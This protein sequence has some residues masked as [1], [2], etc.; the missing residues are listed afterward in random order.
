MLIIGERINATRKHIFAA[1]EKRDTKF[2]QDEAMNQIKAGAN[3]ID[4]NAG[5]KPEREVSD[6]EWLVKTVREVTDAP[7]CIDSANPSAIE[8]GLSKQGKGKPM[9]N[10]I[11]NE[12]D[13][14]NKI[15]PLV[16]KYNCD[17]VALTIEAGE[18]PTTAQKRIEIAKNMLTK[19]RDFGIPLGN[20]YV[21]PCIFPVS[22]DSKQAIVSMDTIKGVKQIFPEVKTIVGLSNISYGLPTR[23]IINSTFLILLVSI[24]LDAAIIDPTEKKMMAALKAAN[25]LLDKDEYC[26]EYITAHREGLFS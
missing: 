9:I 5:G 19:V 11:T 15:L 3:L 13:R 20:V 4:I 14:L 1:M 17:V 25:V 16:K 22:T 21:D 10:S 2:I 18:I 23:G 7:L 12:E 26:L 8:V 24:G 6:M